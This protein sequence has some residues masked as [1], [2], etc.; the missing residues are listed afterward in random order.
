MFLPADDVQ[1]WT[2]CFALSLEEAV[3]VLDLPGTR[4]QKSLT[5]RPLSGA[6]GAAG[7]W[8]VLIPASTGEGAIG[9]TVFQILPHGE[10]LLWGG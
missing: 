6:F 8:V 9:L 2:A 4:F 3:A 7:P 10:I 1:P 5:P